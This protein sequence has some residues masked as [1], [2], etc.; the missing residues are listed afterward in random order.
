VI[1]NALLIA[2][3]AV[4]GQAGGEA[5]EPQ[6]LSLTV[7]SFN[8]RHGLAKD[9]ENAWP[10]RREMVVETIKQQDPDI[11]GLQECLN[12]QAEYLEEELKGYRY[13]GVGREKDCGGERCAIFYKERNVSPLATGTFW[14]SETPSVPGSKSWDSSLPRIAT[15]GDFYHHASGKVVHVVNTHFDHVGEVA[16]AES[17]K[18]LARHA[19]ERPD[20]TV[21]VTGDFNSI[22]EDSPA[23][24]HLIEGGLTDAWNAA[25]ERVG[26]PAT[27]GAFKA[28]KEN[29]QRRIDWVLLRGPL[30]CL[31]AETVLYNVDGR[32]PSDHYPVVVKLSE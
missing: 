20:A 8:I 29:D 7:M 3:A 18:L 21:V 9:G 5:A 15:W 25:A 19:A 12:F 17:G 26:P 28:P 11:I 24:T 14:L 23:Y 16:R 22:A 10:K 27:W 30:K 31:R 32:Y 6:P 4:L 1:I 2:A 13:I